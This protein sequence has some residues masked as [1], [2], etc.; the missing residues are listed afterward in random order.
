MRTKNFTLIEL[1]V[2]IAIIAILASMLLP[3]LNQA[4][5][6]ARSISC[7]NQLKQ[8]GQGFVFYEDDNDSYLP[9]YNKGG[10]IG[11]W[12]K[13]L[14]DNYL[15]RKIFYCPSLLGAEP[16]KQ[17]EWHDTYGLLYPGYGI[18][19]KGVASA[20]Y[21]HHP[22]DYALRYA[23]QRKLSS[24]RRPTETYAVMDTLANPFPATRYGHYRF[25]TGVST[26]TSYG[27]PD[28]RH[29]SS[30]NCLYVDG[31]VKNIRVAV[32]GSQAGVYQA[33]TIGGAC[34]DGI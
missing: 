1:L 9:H 6:K 31:H 26:S 10:T 17:D 8:Q 32:P 14:I 22:D 34:W 20:C 18:N 15:P 19:Y 3:A 23:L 7:V 11:T 2:V 12:N 24:F 25:N 13:A 5:E 4:R 21:T 28:P 29:A 33:L 16:H 30:V 27:T